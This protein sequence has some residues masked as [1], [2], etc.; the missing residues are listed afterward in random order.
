MWRAR[1]PSVQSHRRRLEVWAAE[2]Q[3]SFELTSM[4]FVP[5]ENGAERTR[6]Y[7]GTERWLGWYSPRENEAKLDEY[8]QCLNI[9][10]STLEFHLRWPAVDVHLIGRI[11]IEEEDL[12]SK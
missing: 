6:F 7:C 4:C 11:M 1:K 2:A 8:K 3:N 5:R 12:S 10:D 9:L